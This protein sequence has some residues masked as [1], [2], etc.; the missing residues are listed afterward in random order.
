LGV[1]DFGVIGGGKD[2]PVTFAKRC[3]APHSIAKEHNH[4]VIEHRNSVAIGSRD[5][6]HQPQRKRGSIIGVHAQD[7]IRRSRRA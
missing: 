7:A 6:A 2:Y 4:K 5:F 3:A 1:V